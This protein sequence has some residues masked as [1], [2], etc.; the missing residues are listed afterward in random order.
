LDSGRVEFAGVDGVYRP[1]LF[2]QVREFLAKGALIVHFRLAYAYLAG[3]GQYDEACSD[4]Q[5]CENAGMVLG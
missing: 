4:H 1:Q 3:Y 2:F 5:Q